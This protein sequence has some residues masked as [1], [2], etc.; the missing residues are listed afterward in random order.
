MSESEVIGGRLGRH[1][2]SGPPY[3]T[4]WMPLRV[5]LAALFIASTLSLISFSHC[6]ASDWRSPDMYTHVCYSEPA[7]L[8]QS[9]GL[10]QHRN[11]FTAFG[12][13]EAMSYPILAN[14][15]LYLLSW[16]VP[17]GTAAERRSNFF[18]LFAVVSILGLT[19]T[20]L[21]VALLRRWQDALLV[22]LAPAGL[23]ALFIGWEA[24]AALTLMV[25]LYFYRRGS[26]ILTGLM[27][28]I[29]ILHS[30]YPVVLLAGFYLAKKGVDRIA[31]VA[32]AT[33]AA[34]TVAVQLLYGN[35]LAAFA[36]LLRGG[37][38]YGSIWFVLSSKVTIN[39]LNLYWLASLLLLFAGVAIVIKRTHRTPSLEQGLLVAMLV[40]FITT[41][42]YAPQ[43]VLFLIPLVVLAG[44]RWRDFALWQ[45]IEVG[46]QVLLWQYVAS[47]NG[48]PKAIPANVYSWVVIAHIAGLVYLLWRTVQLMPIKQKEMQYLN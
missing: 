30:I 4:W 6:R 39:N 15:R 31:L 41:K 44:L 3:R 8:Y 29:A 43:Q 48:A 27:I 45:G 21:L 16:L 17:T 10:D 11:P 34:V 14:A 26:P 12:E 32:V 19:F 40:Y 9:A 42:S 37:A 35:S 24:P 38:G 47:V 18:D 46:Y 33:W 22:A 1:A 7:V 13:Q 2:R 20:T 36:E 25:A 28:G 23:L 5:L